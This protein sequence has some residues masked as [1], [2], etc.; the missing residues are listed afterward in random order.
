MFED[1]KQEID[2]EARSKNLEKKLLEGYDLLKESR[3]EIKNLQD[4]NRIIDRKWNN[5]YQDCRRM[6]GILSKEITKDRLDEIMKE[7]TEIERILDENNILDES[8]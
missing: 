4:E 2:Y 6:A 8:D 1:I 5:S 3:D 7:Q